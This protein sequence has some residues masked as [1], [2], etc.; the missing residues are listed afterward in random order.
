[1][2]I[3]MREPM[4]RLCDSPDSLSFCF[5]GFAL[6]LIISFNTGIREGAKL[7]LGIRETSRRCREWGGQLGREG[8]PNYDLELEKIPVDVRGGTNCVVFKERNTL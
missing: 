4:P 7:S 8:G 1:M 2:D 6:P 5:L 3:L